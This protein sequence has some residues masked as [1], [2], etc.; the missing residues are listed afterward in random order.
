M[1]QAYALFWQRRKNEKHILIA[2]C[3]EHHC[4]SIVA[5]FEWEGRWY[6]QPLDA[7]ME[8]LAEFSKQDA[9]LKSVLWPQKDKN[10]KPTELQV[11]ALKRIAKGESISDKKARELD[12][13]GLVRIILSDRFIVNN[14]LLIEDL[15][16]TDEGRKY[17]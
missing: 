11:E 3:T 9:Y 6:I 4:S 15:Y 10:L 16:I 14:M 12:D 13:K 17:L 8:E 1:R 2:I 5:H 7:T